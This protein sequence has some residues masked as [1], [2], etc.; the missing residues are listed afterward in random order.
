ML[1]KTIVALLFVLQLSTAQAEACPAWSMER[2]REE[3][4]QLRQTLTTWDDHYHRQGISLVSDELYDQSRQRLLNLQA[5]FELAQDDNPPLASARGPVRHPIPHTG[6]AK[7]ADEQAVAH[8]MHDKQGIWIQPKIDGVAAT[9]IYR[10]G[11][12]VRLLSR[13]DGVQG[14]D[15]SHH[16]PQLS[17]ISRQLPQPLDLVLQGELYWRLSSHVQATEGS[18]NARGTV[19]GLMARKH[20]SNE[21]GANIGL[22]VWDWPAGPATQAERLARLVELG[23]PDSQHYSVSIKTYEQA[24]DWRQRWYRSPLPFATDGVILR[25]DSRPPAARW[26]AKAPYWIAAWKHPFAQALAE[27]HKVHFRIGRT[28][29]VTP[30]LQLQPVVLDD[31]RITQVSLGSLGRWQA[32]DVRPGDQV[33]ISLAGLTIPRLEQV[34]HRSVQRQPLQPPANGQFHAMSCWQASPGCEEQFIA[35]LAWLSGK[36]GLHI[37]GVGPGTWRHLVE[38]GAISTLGDWLEL[39]NAQLTPIPGISEGRSRHLLKRFSEAR[40]RPFEQW[41]RALGAPVP[42]AT[43]FDGDWSTLAARS[44]EDW[45]REPGIGVRQAKQLEDFFQS[46]ELLALTQKLRAQAVAGF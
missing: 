35:R 41:L 17:A 30:V 3:V 26:R 22:F 40:S 23:F 9:L 11:R 13:G 33:A 27:V 14:H 45:Q 16:I 8:W 32:L 19:A 43:K 4:A 15:W 24:A 28:G 12:L 29:K 44:A 42:R 25:Q 46:Q 39:D 18:V 1:L 37:P 6:V 20:L 31:R 34:V 2:A 10:Q 5:C 36:Q 21:Q 38:H 7:L